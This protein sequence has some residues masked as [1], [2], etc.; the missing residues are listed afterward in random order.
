[1]VTTKNWHA[2]WVMLGLLLTMAGC[3][4]K[5]PR[6]LLDGERLL[7]EGKFAQAISRL[8]TATQH[9]PGNAQAWN[10]L[11]LAYHRAG[12]PA[13]ALKAYEQA[14]RCDANLVPVRFNLGCLHLEQNNPSAAI[15]ELTA[16]TL[17]QRDSVEGW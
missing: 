6:A 5:G 4:P 13:A 2:C 9:L 1:M 17:L 3:T 15:G 7:S 10:H 11:G 14:R 8:T 12:Q 16:Y